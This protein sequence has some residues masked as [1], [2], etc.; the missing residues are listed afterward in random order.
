MNMKKVK[1]EIILKNRYTGDVVHTSEQDYNNEQNKDGIKFIYVFDP[2][3]PTRV[4][5][6]NK[7]AFEKITK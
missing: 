7:E 4:Y 1:K 6:V 3:N 2:A 5:L